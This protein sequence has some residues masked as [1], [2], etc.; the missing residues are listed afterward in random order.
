MILRPLLAG[1]AVLLVALPARAERPLD[2]LTLEYLPSRALTDHCP[3]VEFITYEVQLRLGYNLFKPTAP[4]HVTV[5]VDRAKGQFSSTVEIRDDD[6]KITDFYDFLESDCTWAVRSA[7]IMIAV[8][9]TRL[10]EPLPC[11]PAPLPPAPSSPPAPPPRPPAPALAPPERLRFQAGLASVFS[12]GKAPSVLGGASWFL[13]VRWR[14]FSAALE[15]R[16]LFA[17]SAGVDDI[18]LRYSFVGASGVTC[19][20]YEW[21][22]ACVRF[23]LGTLFGSSFEGHMNPNHT[24]SS[25]VAV[26]IAG[27]RTITRAL[28]VR[29]YFELM[30][31]TV[32]SRMIS[33]GHESPLWIS[34]SLSASIGLGLVMSR[35][36]LSQET[37]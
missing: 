18:S 30:A 23:E 37:K 36:G 15:G 32:S 35:A 29:P 7:V 20:H 8:K 6:G 31:K 12:V 3:S 4:K 1:S 14:D 5:K 28:M 17:P 27:D 22:L 26:R 33:T 19:L 25:G 9:F 13:G 34:P 16:A 11:I 2:E 10:P 24:P 21:A